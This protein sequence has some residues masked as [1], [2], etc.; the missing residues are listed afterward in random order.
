MPLRTPLCI[1]WPRPL[2]AGRCAGVSHD[3]PQSGFGAPAPPSPHAGWGAPAP[4]WRSCIGGDG[5]EAAALV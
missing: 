1:H 2:G 5:V 4:R 3:F